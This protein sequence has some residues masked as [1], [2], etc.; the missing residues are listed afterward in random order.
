[1]LPFKNLLFCSLPQSIIPIHTYTRTYTRTHTQQHYSFG[2]GPHVV[3]ITYLL[4]GQTSP[5]D[6]TRHKFK[7]ELAPLELV[8]HAIHLFLEQVDHG[9]LEDTHFYLNGPHIV[10]TGPQ[11]DWGEHEY[12]EEGFKSDLDVT[13]SEKISQ[14]AISTIEKYERQAAS[15]KVPAYDD[16]EYE[17]YYSEEDYYEEEKRTKDFQD[18]GLSE[19]AFPD[20][21]HEFPHLPWTVGY[22]GRPGGPDWYINKVDNSIGHGPGGQTQHNLEE[23]GDSCFGIISA[24]G[25]GRALMAS[26]I[27]SKDVYADKTEW[28]HFITR[29]V[30]IVQAEVLTKSPILDKHLHLDHLHSQHRVFGKKI[31]DAEKE[32]MVAKKNSL[33]AA[34]K[35]PEQHSANVP[36]M[37]GAAEA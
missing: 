25:N 20:Y 24:E 23:Q 29:P 12:D 31:S 34:G 8:P 1:M 33:L 5:Q 19:L 16:D 7:I 27:F 15:S 30:R 3:E 11:P 21:H 13:Q 37:D 14:D 26:N 9:L 36:R 17:S 10:Q 32:E 22:T 35:S 4:R 2:P 6:D 28:H 18:L